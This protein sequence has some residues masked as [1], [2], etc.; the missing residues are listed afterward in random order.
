MNESTLL[1][2][3]I[4]E[5]EEHLE[6]IERNLLRLEA[7]PQNQDLLHEIFRSAHTIKG[8]AEYLGIER[9][10]SLAHKLESVL[11]LLRRGA[12]SLEASTMDVLMNARDR[13]ASLLRDLVQTG[14]E[15]TDTADLTERLDRLMN[16]PASVES[17][18][19]DTPAPSPEIPGG[20]TQPPPE[21]HDDLKEIFKEQVFKILEIIE[22]TAS[23]EGAADKLDRLQ[24]QIEELERITVYA[25]QPGFASLLTGLRRSAENMKPG[26]EAASLASALQALKALLSPP[27]PPDPPRQTP[28]G[29]PSSGASLA[30]P[31]SPAP[32][33]E[34]SG[35]H[36]RRGIPSL[37]KEEIYK[38]DY[39]Q[40]LFSIFIGHLQEQTAFL[41]L[42][43]AGTS[44]AEDPAD[45]IMKCQDCVRSMRSSANYM[46]YP[47]L[48]E[49]FDHWLKEIET[50]REEEG[51]GEK[52][53]LSF[54]EK[55]L[56]EMAKILPPS[57]E[58]KKTVETSALS[59]A[60]EFSSSRRP[61]ASTDD[62]EKAP[63]EDPD[64]LPTT[65]SR[66][67]N[68]P[69]SPRDELVETPLPLENSLSAES[70]STPI[71]EKNGLLDQ[72]PTSAPREDKKPAEAEVH[73]SPKPAEGERESAPSKDFSGED[74]GEKIAKHNLRVDAKKID[75][76]MNQVGELVVN[77][78][79][80]SQLAMEMK[81]LQR[82]WLENNRL[83]QREAK[84]FK[85]FAFRLHEAS[86]ALG[87]VA[88]DL[89]EGV[90]KVRMLPIGQLFSRYPRLI[91]QLAQETEKRVH[92]EISGEETELDKMVIE[93]VSDPLVHLL[94]NAVDHGIEG[95]DERRRLG[96]PP[97]GT[98]KLTAYH[99]SNNVVIE[100][101]DDGRGMDPQVLKNT[102]LDKGLL[103]KAEAERMTSREL[104][105]LIM[106]PGF[107]TAS[108]VT[109]TSGRGVGMD[110]VKKNIEKLN[111]TI[112]MDSVSGEGTRFRIK[113]PLTLAIIQ[114]L[115]V[116]VGND[117]FTIPL[118]SVVETLRFFREEIS[119][120][121]GIEVIHLRHST[122]PLIRLSSLFK[123]PQPEQD[124][125]KAFVVIISM[126]TKQLGLVVDSLVGEQE[127]VIK[128]LV[129]YLQEKSGFT[130][131]TILGD[132]RISLILDVYEL[133]GLALRREAQRRTSLESLSAKS[134]RPASPSLP[135]PGA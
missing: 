113:I 12:R 70:I 78:A 18:P 8:S 27:Q 39:D 84:Q 38:E 63:G 131:A 135:G 33:G 111:G 64:P 117:I 134:R 129:D 77:R 58:D 49:F 114:A 124:S 130:G 86:S 68:P 4:A 118:A 55:Y 30:E 43:I 71:N 62:K 52:V 79:W 102:A 69:L 6:T 74:H 82:L 32:L 72:D 47:S 91:R 26:S 45:L 28:I 105:S 123:Y 94:R 73:T 107:S 89:Q 5:S 56:E 66:P 109:K 42:R 61:P 10:A 41:K 54:M 83:D 51:K 97:E 103:T 81:D 14:S 50:A 120:V 128:P 1:Q 115:L 25:P 34:D 101:A 98:I 75:A 88:N 35:S 21:S 46:D 3:F 132:G 11:D 67:G 13:M 127:V 90:M 57:L 106:K 116:R 31:P 100:V 15:V 36:P 19:V 95:S 22:K 133:A 17:P 29:E 59:E 16:P 65:E 40:E 104:L 44:S 126:G 122:I 76:L 87:R 108:Q 23:E 92:L 112:E 60:P 96:K 125:R 110:V 119:T 37:Q 7:D 85:S 20:G 24:K 99:E 9:I 48:V 93:E 80:F 121:E 2:E 53:P